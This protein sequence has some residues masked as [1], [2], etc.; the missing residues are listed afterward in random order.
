MDAVEYLKARARMCKASQKSAGACNDCP[1]YTGVSHCYNLGELGDPEKMVAIV[2]EWAKEHPVKTRQGELLKL[3]PKACINADGYF[4]LCPKIVEN[5]FDPN[6]GCHSTSCSQC[7]KE[8]WL[9][10]VEP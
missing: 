3:F 1:A 6:F 2:E 9:A 5:G 10:E 8:F 7:R 4:S